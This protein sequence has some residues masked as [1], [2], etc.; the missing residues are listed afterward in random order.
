M[1]RPVGAAICRAP[2]ATIVSDEQA[3][4]DPGHCNLVNVCAEGDVNPARSGYEL[5]EESKTSG[6]EDVRIGRVHNAILVVGKVTQVDREFEPSRHCCPCIIG[7]PMMRPICV[8]G[9]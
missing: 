6:V 3:T 4:A 8:S 9:E 5:P 7:S 2:H 1:I